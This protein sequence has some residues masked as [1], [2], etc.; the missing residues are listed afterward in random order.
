MPLID[1]SYFTV[2]FAL[3]AYLRYLVPMYMHIPIHKF[4]IYFLQRKFHLH[5]LAGFI[6]IAV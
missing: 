5:I 4:V 3:D 1:Y 2:Y 6:P